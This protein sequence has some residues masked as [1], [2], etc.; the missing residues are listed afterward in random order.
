MELT[1]TLKNG[2]E[3][4]C[5][6]E[7]NKY[8]AV[9]PQYPV[10]YKN[11]CWCIQ[12][13]KKQVKDILGM[14]VEHDQNFIKLDVEYKYD[15]YEKMMN[16]VQGIKELTWADMLKENT[17]LKLW[18]AVNSGGDT[19]ID[20]P[21]DL[22]KIEKKLVQLINWKNVDGRDLATIPAL[23]LQK[24]VEIIETRQNKSESKEKEKIE[25]FRK[26]AEKTG[27]PQV[28][29]KYSEEC[30][31]S[32]DSCDIDNIVV[33]INSDGSQSEERHHSY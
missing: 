17:E 26:L 24:L 16:D 10:Q 1:A 25:S 22:K 21:K 33:Y 32:V 29:Y 7:I 4:N 15:E 13:T 14:S 23:D 11:S 12:L 19:I 2:T 31:G 9:I 5:N 27:T 28:L 20:L 30:D 8:G 18:W 6:I 3:I